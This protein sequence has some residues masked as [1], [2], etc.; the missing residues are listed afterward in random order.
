M[1]HSHIPSYCGENFLILNHGYKGL[2]S[3]ISGFLF[4]I[5]PVALD[6]LIAI[7]YLAIFFNMW[8]SILIS[9]TFVIFFCNKQLINIIVLIYISFNVFLL[10]FSIYNLYE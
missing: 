4:D 7:V 8:F 1:I 6:F 10:I 2:E 5:L 9:L 3:F